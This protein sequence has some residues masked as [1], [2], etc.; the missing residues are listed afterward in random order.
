MSYSAS[1]GGVIALTTAMAVQHGRGNI[2][3]NCIAPGAIYTPMVAGEMTEEARDLR[4]RSNPLGT[5]GTAWDVAWAAVFLASD[6]AGWI[7]GA[8]LPIDG[9]RTATTSIS[10]WP[11]MQG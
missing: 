8:V 1:K 7:T 4:R 5:E 11:L 6:E 9:G 10:L 2:R 3:V